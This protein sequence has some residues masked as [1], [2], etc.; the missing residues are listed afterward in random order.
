MTPRRPSFK[1]LEPKNEHSDKPS[2][3]APG[4][5]E[6]ADQVAPQFWELADL[7]GQEDQAEAVTSTDECR[8]LADP[9]VR[10]CQADEP[11]VLATFHK[12][13]PVGQVQR[14]VAPRHRPRSP[15]SKY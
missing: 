10:R 7:V 1:P 13:S 6:L 14:E 3:V 11:A 12:A 5:L 9:T 2:G 4:V 8:T 15:Q